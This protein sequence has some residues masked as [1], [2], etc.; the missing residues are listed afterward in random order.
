M[1]Y[2]NIE[3]IRYHRNNDPVDFEAVKKNIEKYGMLFP[4]T[5]TPIKVTKTNGE[6]QDKY[7]LIDGRHRL[8]S[9][10]ALGHKTIWA[11]IS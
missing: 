6:I 1:T 7:F 3:D 9:Y 11:I 8:E 5:V 10:K 4:I 2:I